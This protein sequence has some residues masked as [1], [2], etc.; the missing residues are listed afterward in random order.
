MKDVT[1]K[2]QRATKTI[3]LKGRINQM[4]LRRRKAELIKMADSYLKPHSLLYPHDTTMVH[5]SPPM[6]PISSM[7][8][9]ITKTLPIYTNMMYYPI[10]NTY[11]Y[12]Y[13]PFNNW[14]TNIT[15]PVA[16][17]VLYEFPQMY[18]PQVHPPAQECNY[19][20]CVCRTCV[21]VETTA[22]SV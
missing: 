5:L 4:L 3:P 13:H 16:T 11:P 6:T 22:S 9:E 15:G 7:S 14:N 18:S 19:S 8:M 2:T 12:N 17:P 21:H 20:E 10:F 1:I